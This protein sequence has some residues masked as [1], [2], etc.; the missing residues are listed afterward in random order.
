MATQL[1]LLQGGYQDGIFINASKPITGT[2][3]STTS[4]K[5]VYFQEDSVINTFTNTADGNEKLLW[6]IGTESIKAGTLLFAHRG[7]GIKSLTLTS[8]SG[9][10]FDKAI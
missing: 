1:E 3:A 2:T 6:N 7:L 10:L 5:F 8:G 9:F 4:Y